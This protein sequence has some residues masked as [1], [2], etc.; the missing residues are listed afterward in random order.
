MLCDCQELTDIS[1]FNELLIVQA[2]EKLN[3]IF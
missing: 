1:K 2:F 3:Y